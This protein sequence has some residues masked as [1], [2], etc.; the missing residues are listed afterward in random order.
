LA[1]PLEKT[2]DRYDDAFERLDGWIFRVEAG[3]MT[4]ALLAMS[5]SYFLKIIYEAVIAER[6]FV[7]AFLLRWVHGTESAAPA[8]LVQQIHG[9][10][11]PTVVAVGLLMLGIGA[12]RTAEQQRARAK[13]GADNVRLPWRGA[14]VLLGVVIALAFALL[15][16][17]VVAV[18]SSV[19]C[20]VIYAAMWLLFARRARQ[21]GELGVWL[22]AWIPLSLPVAILLWRIPSQYAWV[23]DLAKILIM[24]V[25]FLG[26]SMASREQ[27]HIL[28]NFGRRLWPTAAKRGFE[29][30]SLATWLMFDVLLLVLGWHLFELHRSSG[31]TMSILPLPEYHISLPVVLSFALMSLR[32]G[33]DLVRVL[34]GREAI[35]VV[36]VVT[37]T[38]ALVVDPDGDATEAT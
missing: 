34:L 25:G 23:N 28:L 14:I 26:A 29:A 19:L 15:G 22:A 12:A 27:K 1:N 33:A 2:P 5:F 30:A 10:V 37:P 4:F 8:A 32:V 17:L 9:I 16:W 18:P 7:D 13:S 36:A 3:V 31:S 24:Y 6:N 21:R 11:T 38:P 20:A 35:V